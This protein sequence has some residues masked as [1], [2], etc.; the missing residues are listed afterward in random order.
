MFFWRGGHCSFIFCTRAPAFGALELA[1]LG[2]WL[3]VPVASLIADVFKHIPRGFDFGAS[4]MSLLTTTIS[5]TPGSPR[6]A[7][8][9]IPAFDA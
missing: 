9:C 3:G 5:Q 7:H 8:F 6:H 2:A 4:Y 1:L